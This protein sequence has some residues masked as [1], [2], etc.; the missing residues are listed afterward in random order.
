VVCEVA[1]QYPDV[2]LDHLLVDNCAMQLVLNPKRFD[3]VLTENLFGDI[4]SDEGAVLA[5]SIGM[6]PSAS[7]GSRRASGVSVGL[8][9]PVHG[10]APDIT[11]QGKANPLGAIGSVA[12]MLEYSFGLLEEAGAIYKGIE[13]VLESG[14]VTADLNPAGKPAST[15]EVGDAICAFLARKSKSEVVSAK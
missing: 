5:G 3:V 14:T 12:A 9:E 7:I 8:Y 6:L 2:T 11:G 10:S 1:A 13:A 15:S 4:L